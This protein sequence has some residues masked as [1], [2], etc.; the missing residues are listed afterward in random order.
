MAFG[1]TRQSVH[2]IGPVVDDY[3][4]MSFETEIRSGAF[5]VMAVY[6]MGKDESWN[7]TVDDPLEIEYSGFSVVGGYMQEI[8]AGLMHYCLEYD[9]VASDDVASLET[10]Y[11]SP[12]L[13]PGP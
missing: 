1:P 12:R 6:L 8:P 2:L 9:S 5:E 10:T 3:T 7:L 13:R 4:R 11:A